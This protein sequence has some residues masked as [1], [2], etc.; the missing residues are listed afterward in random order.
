MFSLSVRGH[1]LTL[2]LIVKR[3]GGRL[4]IFQDHIYIFA[5]LNCDTELLFH[6][7]HPSNQHV[8]PLKSNLT[9]IWREKKCVDR[10]NVLLAKLAK[11]L[12]PKYLSL[13]IEKARYI[14]SQLYNHG[15]NINFRNLSDLSLL[16]LNS[17][18]FISL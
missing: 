3:G 17:L 13:M 6:P 15:Q 12:G 18:P 9:N 10:V 4:I 14:Y 7:V 1:S 2:L 11:V 16:D 8:I 5:S